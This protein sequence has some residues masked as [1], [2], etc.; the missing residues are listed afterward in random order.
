[1][2]MSWVF[3]SSW[4]CQPCQ[5]VRDLQNYCKTHCKVQLISAT[6]LTPCRTKDD[7]AVIFACREINQASS[8][9]VKFEQHFICTALLPQS[10]ISFRLHLF[11][12]FRWLRRIDW[13]FNRQ[14]LLWLVIFRFQMTQRTNVIFDFDLFASPR[15][16]LTLKFQSRFLHLTW[17]DLPLCSALHVYDR[18]H[19]A[20]SLDVAHALRR[21]N[22]DRIYGH[23]AAV[24]TPLL[25]T[26]Y[27]GLG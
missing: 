23:R 11:P 17:Q 12:L 27:S 4:Q 9:R 14:L 2:R 3:L 7:F 18:L 15:N 8:L 16:H 21:D 6:Y 1:M 22:C 10:R 24:S 13:W 19:P 5:E 25:K 20:V 26:I